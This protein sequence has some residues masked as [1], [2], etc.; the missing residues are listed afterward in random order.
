MVETGGSP[1]F[2][3]FLLQFRVEKGCD[4]T[5]TSFTRPSGSFYIPGQ[6][7]AEFEARYEAAVRAGDELFITERHREICPVVVDLDFRFSSSGD[8]RRRYTSLDV[9]A[10][11][12]EYCGALSAYVD[13][14]SFDVFVMEKPGP[15]MHKNLLK[16]GVHFLMPDVVTRPSVQYLARRDV[17]PYMETMCT[18][19]ELTNRPEDIIDEAVI[20]RNNWIMYMSKKPGNPPYTVTRVVRYHASRGV[21]EDLDSWESAGLSARLSI[22]NKFVETPLRECTARAVL[23]FEQQVEDKRKQRELLNTLMACGPYTATNTSDSFEIAC[24]LVDILN[25]SRVET[26][27]EWVRLG[28]CLR[29]IDHRLLDKWTEVSRRSPKYVEGECAR[30]WS[31]MRVGGLSIGTLHMWSRT[32]NPEKYHEIVRSSLNDLL[33]KAASGTHYDV[34]RVVHHMYRYEYVCASI[35]NRSWYEFRDHRWVNSDLA[36]SLR[37]RISEDVCKE[38]TQHALRHQQHVVDAVAEEEQKRHVET[39][40]KL[41]GIALKLKTTNFKDNII[42]ECCELFYHEKFEEKLDSNCHLIGFT[43]GVFDLEAHEF[44]EGRPDDFISFS[45]GINYVRFSEDLPFLADI[46]RFWSQVLPDECV[47]VYVLTVMASFLSGHTREERFHIWTGSGSNG[48]SLSVELFDKCLGDYS[49][50]FPV[51][52]LT[53]KRAASNSATSE[54]ARAKGRR[55]ACLQEPSED[56]RLNIGLLKELTGGDKVQARAIY[57]EPVEFKPQ[58]HIALLCNHL[59]HV[60][61]DDGGTWRRIRVVEFK[62]RF[63]EKPVA[64][65]EFPVDLELSQRIEGWKESFMSLLVEMYRTH[66]G[67]RKIAEPPEVTSCTREYQRDNDHFADFLDSCLVRVDREDATLSLTD[68][69]AEFRTWVREDNI[70]VKLPQKREV[71]R[72]LDRAIGKVTRIGNEHVYRGYALRERPMKG[73]DAGA[74]K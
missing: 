31:H 59:P 49:C 51:T 54:I 47:R 36:C 10:F 41:N 20:E 64:A 45:T 7:A 14:P 5:H 4:H 24:K 25:V 72:F 70:P 71:Q 29:N 65:H 66:Y 27:N 1:N 35:R 62:S 16:D 28:W 43:N 73:D 22:R 46:R 57:R 55:F 40:A 23:D 67:N 37:R 30:M 9:D 34:A 8:L 56:E 44:R 69:F 63:V 38:F 39:C 11:L 12:L 15:S 17:L 42:K 3:Q 50:K 6:F 19:L 32:D 68:A 13:T 33:N 26:Y 21:L 48:K 60:P 74:W 2:Y 58:W 18:R 53:Q 61:S 52:L